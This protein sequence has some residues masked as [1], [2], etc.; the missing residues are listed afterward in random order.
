MDQ[1]PDRSYAIALHLCEHRFGQHSSDARSL[2]IGS[3][4]DDHEIAVL[5]QW[6]QTIVLD[7]VVSGHRDDFAVVI[8]DDDLTIERRLFDV[9][10]PNDETGDDL[11]H[12]VEP[13][14]PIV[15]EVERFEGRLVVRRR[16][17]KNHFVALVI[18]IVV[19]LADH[20]FDGDLGGPATRPPLARERR[21]VVC[22]AV[23]AVEMRWIVD[24]RASS[25]PF[26]MREIS[27]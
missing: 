19:P 11:S 24:Q 14:R 3:D 17:A 1:P 16:V 23:S 12:F 26:S 5:G 21:G 20:F 9:V 13:R 10:T 4:G 18:A 25:R 6:P 15:A 8:R 27:A 2:V 7:A 22:V